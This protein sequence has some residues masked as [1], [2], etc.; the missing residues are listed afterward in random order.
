MNPEELASLQVSISEALKS[1]TRE[2]QSKKDVTKLPEYHGDPAKDKMSASAFVRR[3]EM[4]GRAA[5]WTPGETVTHLR[6]ALTGKAEEWFEVE[7]DRTEVGWEEN[8]DMVSTSLIMRFEPGALSPKAVRVLSDL[9]QQ[10]SDGVADFGD[11]LKRY[12]IQWRRTLRVPSS[13]NTE[14]VRTACRIGMRLAYEQVIH[15]LFLLGLKEKV[16]KSVCKKAPSDFEEALGLALD[17][18]IG[19]NNIKGNGEEAKGTK[20]SPVTMEPRAE[21]EKSKEVPTCQYCD[22]KGHTTKVC[23]AFKRDKNRNFNR[24]GNYK[25]SKGKQKKS[26]KKKMTS[27]LNQSES[28]SEDSSDDD[29][30]NRAVS[31]VKKNK[32]KALNFL[33]IA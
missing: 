10:P 15:T 28:D 29:D 30:D 31:A 26:Y 18:E 6:L 8:F 13:M 25:S 5:K 24:D 16:K 21:A 1:A 14:E 2:A 32:K 23:F 17:Y 3:V 27:A 33:G 9:G 7:I 22:K 4:A 12:A 11:R 19:L 20:I